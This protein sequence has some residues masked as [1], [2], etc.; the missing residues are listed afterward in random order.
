MKPGF[1]PRF[2][3]LPPPPHWPPS[4]FCSFLSLSILPLSHLAVHC[5]LPFVSSSN[6]I[7]TIIIIIIIITIIISSSS[8]QAGALL[9]QQALGSR[10]SSP[11]E[12]AVETGDSELGVCLALHWFPFLGIY[13]P[14]CISQVIDSML[15]SKPSPALALLGAPSS[16]L[17]TGRARLFPSPGS[18]WVIPV[19][20]DC[21]LI[22]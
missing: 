19:D 14:V 8:L 10:S 21:S 22:L 6:S 17:L 18:P 3:S 2:P 9:V 12:Q 13:P 4:L 1:Q 7:I 5:S 16:C 11:A 15:P 20:R